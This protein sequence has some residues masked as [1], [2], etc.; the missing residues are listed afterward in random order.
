M[1]TVSE[2]SADSLT[3][4]LVCLESNEVLEP[5]LTQSST[6]STILPFNYKDIKEALI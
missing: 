3:S 1:E 5:P 2:A 6:S 4:L